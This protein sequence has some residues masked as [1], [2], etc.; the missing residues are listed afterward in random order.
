[1]QLSQKKQDKKF[2]EE[3]SFVLFGGE[4]EK[5]GKKQLFPGLIDHFKRLNDMT[6]ALNNAMLGLARRLDVSVED[7][8][9]FSADNDANMKYLDDMRIIGEAK[10]KTEPA[11]E[12][13]V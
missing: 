5:D 13:S 11:P 3:I 7:F 9:K 4:I 8:E 1:M 2:K 6:A 10:T 12:P